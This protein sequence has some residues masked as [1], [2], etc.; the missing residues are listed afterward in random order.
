MLDRFNYRVL[1]QT[2]MQEK[3]GQGKKAYPA[4][5]R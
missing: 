1:V 4:K 2:V 5:E 3:A